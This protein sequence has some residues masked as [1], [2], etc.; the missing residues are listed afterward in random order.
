M[1]SSFC[2]IL[3]FFFIST[4]YFTIK[5]Y[6]NCAFISCRYSKVAKTD[7]SVEHLL[8]LGYVKMSNL[9][10]NQAYKVGNIQVSVLYIVSALKYDSFQI[11]PSYNLYYSLLIYW[12]TYGKYFY[13]GCFTTNRNTDEDS[14]W[15]EMFTS[16]ILP[17]KSSCWWDICKRTFRSE[18][19]SHYHWVDWCLL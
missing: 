18:S 7:E 17:G 6:L 4:Q 9:L 1:S 3:L 15:Q 2:H 14:S 8:E 10:P 5:I 19:C 16:N 13:L 12:N 11:K